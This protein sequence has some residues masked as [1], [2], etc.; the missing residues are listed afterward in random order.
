MYAYRAVQRDLLAVAVKV[1]R[2]TVAEVIA[3]GFATVL[4]ILVILQPKL[5]MSGQS[6]PANC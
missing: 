1:A 3:R 6:S 5:A 4:D 2:Y